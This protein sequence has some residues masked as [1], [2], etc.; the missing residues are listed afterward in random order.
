VLVRHAEK[1]SAERDPELSEKGRAR[2]QRIARL[3][4]HAGV[5]RLV[6]SEYRRTRDTLAPLAELTHVTVEAM[7]AARSKELASML[8]D[9]PEASVTVVA[10]HSNV[11]PALVTELGAPPLRD[12][13]ADGM[14][15]EDDY[16]R[17]VVVSVPCAAA[18]SPSSRV[19]LSSE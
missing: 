7:P 1:G 8:R 2:A 16:G 13:P 9:A 5:T 12:L 3:L 4:A 17:V 18:R 19:E 6:A 14:L 11:L 10:T 15:A